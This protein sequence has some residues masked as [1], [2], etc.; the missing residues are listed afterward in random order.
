VTL[1]A[2]PAF[3]A[4]RPTL[5][6]PSLS[7]D[8]AEIA[9]V[10]GGDIWTV[11]ATGGTAGLLITDPATEGRP[12]FSPDGRGLAFTSNRNGATNIYVMAL[13]T[14]QIRRLT[15]SDASERLDAW[16]RDGKWIYFTSAANDIA[17][18]SDIFRV[19]ATGGTPLE[20]SR[21]RYL[22]EFNAA[23]SP[24]GATLALMAKGRSGGEWWRN[25]HAHIDEAELWL[26]P[27]SETGAYR[28]L[29]GA[30]SKRLWPMWS[31]D[32]QTLFF[33]SDE[34]G[35]ENLWR[36]GLEPGARPRAITT[37][38]D[39][40][41]LFPSISLEG[42]AIVFEREFEIW[43]LD[44]ATGAVAKVPVAL[45]GAPA[46]A[47]ER[48]LN[49]TSFQALALSPDGRKVA[50]ITRGEVF[51]AS[52]RDGGAA[53][54]VTD[55]PGPE[56]SPVWSPDSRRLAYVS[57]RGLG[58]RIVEYDFAT[59]T[60]RFLTDA[61]GY[62]WAP[63]YA[64]DGKSLAY[65]RGR[66]ELRVISL[67]GGDPPRAGTLVFKGALGRRQ[68]SRPTWSPDSK[69]LA[70][71]VTDRRAFRNIWVAPAGGGEARPISFLANGTTS[72]TIAW[73]PD[74]RFILFDT[75]QRN[76]DSGIVRID[77]LPNTPRY[78]EDTFRDLFKGLPTAPAPPPTAMVASRTILVSQ[79]T[80]K[81]E[82]E[83]SRVEPIRIAFEGLRE[84]AGFLPLGA[85]VDTPVISPDGKTLVYRSNRNL[86]A[87]SL[88]ELARD[89]PA[90]EQLTGGR[91]SK[92]GYVFDP[93]SKQIYYLDGGRLSVTTVDSPKPRTIDVN[94]E[95]T[96][97]FDAEKQVIF[98]QAW[99]TLNRDFYDPGFHGR[100]WAALRSRFEPFAQGART[101]DELRRVINLMVGELDSSHV[102]VSRPTEGFGAAPAS[103]V[104]DLG[105]RFDRQAHETG[106]GLTVREIVALGPADIEGS[107]RV[108]DRLL[109]V[110]GRP[111]SDGANLNSYLL[112]RIG[113]R[114]ALTLLSASGARREAVLRPVTLGTASGLLYRQWTRDRRAYV[115]AASGG[116]LGY[117]HIAGM[118]A[119]SVTQLNIDLDAQNQGREGVVIDLRNNQGGFLNGQILDVFTRR[120]FLTMT[121]RGLFGLPSR[122]NL[123][124][125]ALDRPT[126]VVTN[127]YTLSDAENFVEGY[128]GLGLGKV[129]GTPTAGWLIYTSEVNLIDG[130]VFR[131]PFIRV[132][133]AGGR[134]ME[135][136]PRP[137][138]IPVERALGDP[139]DAQLDAA[140][141][142]LLKG[143]GPR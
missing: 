28:R 78:R 36:L 33:M 21:E 18:Q 57:E 94:A 75:G 34:G 1:L 59:G 126:V 113:K 10:S 63:V 17:A 41:V 92:D 110:D 12:L 14:G 39:G 56:S 108:G 22:N 84:R 9:F 89:P 111:L 80:P 96:V 66:D 124:Q 73:S 99:S 122:Q 2:A 46:A 58:S 106:Q 45:R 134:N 82:G 11:P 4:P 120:N 13:A 77:L 70:F 27:V 68:G 107:I 83:K 136:N 35:V 95:M 20:I 117:V 42:R 88:D 137:V 64:P 30:S 49:E 24:D 38:T 61:A 50:L 85:S 8:G 54:R 91:R 79:P 142:E 130:S 139:R 93:G 123:G 87:Y 6:E 48:R 3:A 55:T 100:D 62:D 133:D 118:S 29:L 31:A 40:R 140:V 5:A 102:G 97:R 43:R 44:M 128:R 25:G 67:G 101:P 32:G 98:D 51:A 143:L 125:R 60:E 141:A 76:E 109:A 104:G 90:P 121:P 16:S 7:P 114:T 53:Q 112:D 52:T 103:R 15:T 116:R 47:G 135:R 81:T 71:A 26:K 19:A 86:F 132:D 127:E 115:E 119:A 37:F 105:L 65:V 74:G 72:D 138:D 23:P 69:W 129:V 131:V